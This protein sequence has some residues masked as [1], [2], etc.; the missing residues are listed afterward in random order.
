MKNLNKVYWKNT[1]FKINLI[2]NL[3]VQLYAIIQQNGTIYQ[4]HK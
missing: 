4:I 3:S 1:Q 2:K